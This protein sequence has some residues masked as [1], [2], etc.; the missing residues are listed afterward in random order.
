MGTIPTI[1]SFPSG[2]KVTSSYLNSLKAA[3]DFWATP[4]ECY[5]YPS[6]AQSLASAAWTV[7]GFDTELSDVVQAGDPPSHD[8]VTNNSRLYIRTTG[9]YEIS[10]QVQ[11]VN[12]N[13]GSRQSNVRL[14][15]A[16]N[17]AAGTLLVQN[18]QSAVLTFGTSVMTPTI[19]V[20]L[21]AGDYL[22]LFGYQ[23]SGGALNVQQGQAFTFLRAV[24]V[25]A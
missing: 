16:G 24:L 8:N 5:I 7:L 1:A 18:A 11:F 14:N 15:A 21:T 4:P 19:R 17:I 13:T 20:P 22:E 3:N 25:S 9:K 6:A 10:S 2:G 12:N 23:N